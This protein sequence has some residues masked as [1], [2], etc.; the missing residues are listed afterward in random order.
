[1]FNLAEQ[2]ADVSVPLAPLGLG[3]CAVR[4][5][6]KG[7]DVGIQPGSVSIRITAHGAALLRLTKDS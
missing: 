2:A 6:W 3:A 5:L 4:D 1:M 7:L